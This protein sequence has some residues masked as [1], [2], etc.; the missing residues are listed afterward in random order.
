MKKTQLAW[1]GVVGLLLFAGCGG[2][3]L[4]PPADPEQGR[5]AL[6]SALDAWARGEKSDS[7][8][9]GTPPIQVVDGDWDKGLRLAKYQLAPADRM[10]DPNLLCSV[11]LS[12]RDGRGRAL[13]KRV[14]YHIGT[15]PLI[16]IVRE[17][18]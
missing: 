15:G 11:Q 10:S 17:E 9:G 16:S 2:Q 4:P 12:L 1:G 14:V 8:R 13:T 6:R 7:L 5:E 3:T 18:Q